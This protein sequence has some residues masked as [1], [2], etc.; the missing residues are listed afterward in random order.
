[1]EDKTKK[2]IIIVSLAI[3]LIAV[4][5]IVINGAKKNV[6]LNGDIYETQG[7]DGSGISVPKA[8][9]GV[10]SD[11]APANFSERSSMKAIDSVAAQDVT[12]KRIIKIGNLD[13]K[14]SNADDASQKIAQIA[15]NNGGE[16]FSSNF[17]QTSKN[18]KSG[19]VEIKVP[20]SNFEKTFADIKTIATLVVREST[21]G[22]DVT[23]EYSDLQIQLKNKQAEEQSFLS[24][25]D[26]A[27]KIDDVLAVTREVARVRGEIESLQGQIKFMDSQ[28]DKATITVS[29]T[30]D[31]AITFSDKWRPWQVAKE[32]FNALFKD[33]QGAINFAIVLVIRIIPIIIMYIL[34]FGLL[35]WVGKKL[36][37]KIKG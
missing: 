2:I 24:I 15:K 14:V 12:D 25:L 4:L 6:V 20:M 32:T 11:I 31:T 37:F 13:L 22:T 28:T 30:E 35:Y 33:I 16:V 18:I 19:T 9:L 17:Y 5:V 3:I 21:S 29:M 7:I 23:M 26:R 10:A 36:Y 8:M 1:M 27:G 34:I